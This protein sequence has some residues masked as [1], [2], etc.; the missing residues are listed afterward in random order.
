MSK[1]TIAVLIIAAGY[2][3]RMHDFKPLLPFGD[4]TAIER[5]VQT[6][7]SHGI[8][9]IYVVTGYRQED[10]IATLKSDSIHVV[11]NEDYDKGMFSSIQKGISA[12][13]KNI[14]AFYMQ[15]V[16]LP[17]IKVQSLERLY[18]AYKREQKGVIYPVFFGRKGHPP[19]INMKYKEQICL[20]D[21]EG[22]L[23]RVLESFSADALYVDVYDKAVL[24]DM[25]TKED[26]YNLLAYEA[27]HAPTK[28]ECLAIM[29]QNKVPHRVIKHCE[30]VEKIAYEFY[31]WVASFGLNIDIYALSAAALLHDIVR[32]EKDH[33][34]VGAHK[35]REMGYAS[36]GA[37]IETHMDIV[38][39]ETKPLNANELLYLADKVVGEESVC[40]LEKR[41]EKTLKKCE[42]N[43]EALK[44]IHKRLTSARCIIRKIETITCK[45]F[46]YG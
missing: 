46:P 40:G 42:G 12:M 37:I 11:H 2:S 8:E 4:R 3:S 45:A 23:K 17:L 38:V 1:K 29:M 36:I 25:D 9:H 32:E 7:Q 6:Y 35:I 10:I 13:D 27:M 26:Y 24:M 21:G 44:Y 31:T 28:E 33:A 43:E 15:P 20:S 41:F 18:E 16:D 30:A 14:E 19:L 34:T 39:D 22:G 5:L